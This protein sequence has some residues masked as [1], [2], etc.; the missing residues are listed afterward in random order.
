[1]YMCFSVICVIYVICSTTAA[2]SA[3]HSDQDWLSSSHQSFNCNAL[4]GVTSPGEQYRLG[5]CG[6]GSFVLDIQMKC[7]AGTC[8]HVYIFK[9]YWSGALKLIQCYGAKLIEYRYVIT[10]V[11]IHNGDF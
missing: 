6:V 9:S 3:M 2:H 1:M 8:I 4:C 10:L 11:L 5:V 7:Y